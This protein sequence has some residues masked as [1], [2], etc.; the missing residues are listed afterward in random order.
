MN[1]QEYISSGIVESYVLGLAEEAEQS[2]F[3]R[4][5]DAHIEVR[6]A[7]VAFEEALEREALANAIPP[8]KSLKSKIFSE[9]EVDL[10]QRQSLAPLGDD[11]S[12][13]LPETPVRSINYRCIDYFILPTNE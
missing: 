1:I 8:P 7:R 10:D 12:Q 4:M 5:C 2:E 13:T 6:R 3:E 11:H 9:I